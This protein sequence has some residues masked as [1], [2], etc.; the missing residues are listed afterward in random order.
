MPIETVRD[1]P[2]KELKITAVTYQHAAH[3]GKSDMYF[4]TN[5]KKVGCTFFNNNIKRRTCG[6]ETL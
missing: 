1:L 4:L 6:Q 3:Y 2:N 5:D